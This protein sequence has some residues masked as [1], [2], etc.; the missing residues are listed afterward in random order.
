VHQI[1]VNSLGDTIKEMKNLLDDNN[2]VIESFEYVHGE[3]YQRI[4]F[5]YDS[6]ENLIR[7]RSYDPDG[8]ELLVMAFIYDEENRMIEMSNRNI[9][10]DLG[11]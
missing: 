3:L 7:S 2:L 8:T 1:H 9:I 10:Y 11:G 6:F 5:E 4:S